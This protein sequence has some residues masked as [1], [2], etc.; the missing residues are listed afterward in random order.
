MNFS[1]IEYNIFKAFLLEDSLDRLED[2]GIAV[3]KD[4]REPAKDEH[5]LQD[6]SP[7]IRHQAIQMTNVYVAFFCLENA[8]RELIVQKLSENHG[9][10]W[11]K[12]CVPKK[13]QD[14]VNNLR[15]KERKNKYHA[16]RSDTSIGYTTFG[17]LSQIIISNWDDFSDLFPDQSWINSRFNDLE[18]SRNIIMHTNILPDAEIDRIKSLVRDWLSQVG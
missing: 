10:D 3:R 4:P 12:A 15:S 14:K 1:K 9:A 6:F 8:V 18:M 5:H 13:I 2:N 7:K 11:W 16:Q 17:N